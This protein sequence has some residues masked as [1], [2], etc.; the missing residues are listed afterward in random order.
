MEFSRF[1][2]LYLSF[3]PSGD[4]SVFPGFSFGG[5]AFRPAERTILRPIFFPS[6][7]GMKI[8]ENYKIK[9][10]LNIMGDEWGVTR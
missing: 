9:I 6:E 2:Y 8:S 3:P 5:I 7:A 1:T 4:R 10:K